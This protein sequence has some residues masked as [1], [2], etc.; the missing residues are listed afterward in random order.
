MAPRP[1]CRNGHGLTPML[2]FVDSEGTRRC[3]ICTRATY[4]RY[5][6]RIGGK[7]IHV[8]HAVNPIETAL[9]DAILLES[10][11]PWVK[12]DPSL[13]RKWIADNRP[14]SGD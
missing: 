3:R 7:R 6:D 11:P 2:T 5:L 4:R 14:S 10:A 9:D 1:R 8:D 13:H 12:S